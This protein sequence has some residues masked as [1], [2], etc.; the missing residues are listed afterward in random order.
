MNRARIAKG[1]SATPER[2]G[3]PGVMP[4]R[5]VRP[6]GDPRERPG[7]EPWARSA[8]VDSGRL[9]SG[10]PPVDGDTTSRPGRWRPFRGRDADVPVPPPVVVLPP[11]DRYPAGPVRPVSGAPRPISGGPPRP[12]SG[13]SPKPT[14]SPPRPTSGGSPRPTSGGPPKPTPTTGAPPVRPAVPA[15][16]PRRLPDVRQLRTLTLVVVLLALLGAVPLFLGVRAAAR[17]PVFA[18]LD[19][20]RLPTWAARIPV[21]EAHGSRWC[22]KQCRLRERTWQ[23]ERGP[24]ETAAAYSTR[25]CRLERSISPKK[26]SSRPRPVDPPAALLRAYR[27][28]DRPRGGP[29]DCGVRAAARPARVRGIGG[30]RA[31]VQ[32]GGDPR[33]AHLT[34]HHR[35]RRAD[36]GRPPGA[37]PSLTVGSARWRGVH[38]CALRR[39]GCHLEGSPRWSRP[40][41][42]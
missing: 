28:P 5:H 24:E 2:S 3:P 34:V 30:D 20:L 14:S 41:R 33:R 19:S 4:D 23:S 35:D 32:P 42:S 8:P 36:T 12:T 27:P 25:G 22:I 9:L 40:A 13:G 26:R 7:T 6:A 16:A 1:S 15:A 11:P 39:L 38:S 17:D 21:D 18:G 31:G 10:E 37:R 29:V